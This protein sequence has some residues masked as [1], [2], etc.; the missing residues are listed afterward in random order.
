VLNVFPD[1]ETHGAVHDMRFLYAS[2]FAIG[3]SDTN[4]NETSRAAK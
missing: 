4:A 2:I 1:E 3:A